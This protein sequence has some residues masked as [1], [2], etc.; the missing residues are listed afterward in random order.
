MIVQVIHKEEI[1]NFK[2]AAVHVENQ[3]E[4]KRQLQSAMRL[5]NEFKSKTKITFMT[6]D[7]PKSV[8]TT[9]WTVTDLYIQIKSGVVIPLGSLLKI[10]Y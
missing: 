9:V 5:G 10:E 7:G 3:A 6:L 8:E 1:P 2:F 4:L